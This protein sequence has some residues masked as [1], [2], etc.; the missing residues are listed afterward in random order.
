MFRGQ[1]TSCVRDYTRIGDNIAR[2]FEIP[3]VTHEQNSAARAGYGGNLAVG[4]SDRPS[5]A[6]A[7]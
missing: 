6:T 7:A 1:R 2:T 4:L 5:R 3:H